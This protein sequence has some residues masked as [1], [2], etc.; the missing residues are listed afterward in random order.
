MLASRMLQAQPSIDD[1]IR[2]A[3]LSGASPGLDHGL[4]QGAVDLVE[5]ALAAALPQYT[6]EY[7]L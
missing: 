3:T 6:P 5:E 7:R 1:I 2:E 4:G